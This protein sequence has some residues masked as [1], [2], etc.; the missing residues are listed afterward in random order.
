MRG[1]FPGPATRANE[2]FDEEKFA[3]AERQ[4]RDEY[5]TSAQLE[6]LAS[7][8]A[9][10]DDMI[11]QVDTKF[12]PVMVDDDMAE[13]ADKESGM[14]RRTNSPVVE[15]LITARARVRHQT[16]RLQ[17]IIERAQI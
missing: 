14:D 9:V 2:A 5:S 12:S 3:R 16:R 4:P 10:L 7:E 11:T 13:Q 17:Y 15:T 6:A 8:L 1:E